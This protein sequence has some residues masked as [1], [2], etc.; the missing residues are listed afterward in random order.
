MGKK[1]PGPACRAPALQ[2]AGPTAAAQPCPRRQAGSHFRL[3]QAGLRLPSAQARI[4]FIPLQLEFLP[5][6]SGV[7]AGKGE[8]L[9]LVLLRLCREGHSTIWQGWATHFVLLEWTF[10]T[11]LFT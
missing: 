11:R 4:Q 3:W 2:P 1:Q 5:K 8:G 6:K 7:P 9:G 10:L